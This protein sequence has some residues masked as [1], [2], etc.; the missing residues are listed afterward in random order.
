MPA[1]AWLFGLNPMM[2]GALFAALAAAA[3]GGGVWWLR[4]DAVQG[5]RDRSAL[6]AAEEV[7][8]TVIEKGKIETEV[9]D[10]S[11]D[12]LRDSLGIPR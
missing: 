5:E 2:R 4:A 10:E 9:R 12:A 1:I 7:I 6:V 11:D 3:L 8:E